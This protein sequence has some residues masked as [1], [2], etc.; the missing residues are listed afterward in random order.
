ME[1]LSQGLI[2]RLKHPE[3]ETRIDALRELYHLGVDD[4]KLIPLIA[5]HIVHALNDDNQAV[6]ALAAR[7]V[8]VLANQG[9]KH[10]SAA[11]DRLIELTGIITGIDPYKRSDKD[12]DSFM[13]LHSALKELGGKKAVEFYL[14]LSKKPDHFLSLIHPADALS[15]IQEMLKNN[16]QAGKDNP[17]HI[18]ALIHL[19]NKRFTPQ[20]RKKFITEWEKPGNKDKPE[21]FW[22]KLSEEFRGKEIKAR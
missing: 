6:H 2:K 21:S 22:K 4:E 7:A 16:P 14:R 10:F 3:T 19:P 11:E 15:T 1:K 12:L 20:A 9:R 13:N 5:P 17:P 18:R 8:S